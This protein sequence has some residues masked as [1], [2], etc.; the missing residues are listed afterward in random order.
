[1]NADQYF[2]DPFKQFPNSIKSVVVHGLVKDNDG[3]DARLVIDRGSY[4]PYL[5]STPVREE[6]HGAQLAAYKDRAIEARPVMPPDGTLEVHLMLRKQLDGQQSRDP[7]RAVYS[8]S[9]DT[10]RS[11]TEV[12]QFRMPPLVIKVASER[13]GRDLAAEAA[14]YNHLPCLQ[15]SVLPRCYGYFRRVVDLHNYVVVPWTPDCE[16]PR[17]EADFDIFKMPNSHASLNVLLLERV[18][19]HI[20]T[21][22][23]D[24]SAQDQLR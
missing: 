13:G 22:L 6:R 9:V 21:G 2:W 17:S 12:L 5:R 10:K 7:G 15:G 1:M 18:G 14:M 23:H 3:N 16:L 20:P 8:V 11:S 24:K 4:T 19:N